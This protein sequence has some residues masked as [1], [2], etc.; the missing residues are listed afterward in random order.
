MASELGTEVLTHP[1]R[2]N[3]G[4]LINENNA[5]RDEVKSYYCSDGMFRQDRLYFSKLREAPALG[6]GIDA[7]LAFTKK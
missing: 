5:L 1:F 4:A 7:H 2:T 3:L 6:A